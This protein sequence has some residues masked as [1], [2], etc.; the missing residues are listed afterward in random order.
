VDFV[1]IP[2]SLWHY[3]TEQ[4]RLSNLKLHS[5][6]RCNYFV[7]TLLNGRIGSERILT[8]GELNFVKHEVQKG[9]WPTE[10]LGIRSANE[11]ATKLREWY[12]RVHAAAPEQLETCSRPH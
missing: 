11:L 9:I 10:Y 4:L 12:A 3:A 6:L 2:N 7:A 5:L 1:D 8:D